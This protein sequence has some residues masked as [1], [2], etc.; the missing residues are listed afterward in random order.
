MKT[1]KMMLM[2]QNRKKLSVQ[3]MYFNRY[4]LVRYASALFFFT[5]LYWFLS[6]LMSGSS[7]F[8]I[9]LILIITLIASVVEQV[10]LYSAHTNNARYTKYSFITL[11]LTNVWLIISI[12]FLS[13][14]HQLYPFLTNQMKYRVFI[15]I[16]L[17]LGI[18]LSAIIL[19][20]LKKIK[21]NEDKHFERIKQ[22][23]NIIK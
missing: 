11:L 4:L 18:V 7:L 1:N 10:K 23:E 19:R 9:P 6:L 15:L 21:Y 2:E 16:V 22:Y 20:R 17:V 14:F 8:V 5:N 3:S 12:S 13:M